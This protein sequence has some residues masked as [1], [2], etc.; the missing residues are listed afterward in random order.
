MEA[1][2]TTWLGGEWIREPSE[3]E[4]KI[5]RE[6]RG[7]EGMKEAFERSSPSERSTETL[8]SP[9]RACEGSASLISVPVHMELGRT[10]H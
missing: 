6:G 5:S 8:M 2:A 3:R 10:A 4:K 1:L 9:V 7:K